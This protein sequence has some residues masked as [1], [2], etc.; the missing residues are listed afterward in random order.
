M[1]NP[2]QLRGILGGLAPALFLKR[3]QM[4]FSAYKSADNNPIIKL[5]SNEIRNIPVIFLPL[6]NLKTV[7]PSYIL[8]FE[9]FFK[10]S[11][12]VD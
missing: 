11:I 2:A 12:L 6:L 8:I 1:G 3:I 4:P 9:K 5:E 10:V 7:I